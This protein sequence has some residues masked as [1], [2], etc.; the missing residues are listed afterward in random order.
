MI[1]DPCLR[2]LGERAFQRQGQ[3]TRSWPDAVIQLF[4]RHN[5][6]TR[7][8]ETWFEGYPQCFPE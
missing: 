3:A 7:P 6:N 1:T 5:W 8:T 2:R 4:R